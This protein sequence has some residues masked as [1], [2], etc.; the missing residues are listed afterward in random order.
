M[1]AAVAV[2]S[3][4]VIV[5]ASVIA[6]DSVEAEAREVGLGIEAAEGLVVIAVIVVIVTGITAGRQA[7]AVFRALP[8][9]FRQPH[10]QTPPRMPRQDLVV[11]EVASRAPKASRVPVARHT[12]VRGVAAD[13]TAAAAEVGINL[14]THLKT[15]DMV[16]SRPTTTKIA[17]VEHPVEYPV[18][19][20]AERPVDPRGLVVTGTETG[21]TMAGSGATTMTGAAVTVT[22]DAISRAQATPARQ[23]CF[24]GEMKAALTLVLTGSHRSHSPVVHR[25]LLVYIYFTPHFEKRSFYSCYRTPTADWGKYVVYVTACSQSSSRR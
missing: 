8:Q 22:A 9:M 19:R 3:E 10:L 23:K 16:S 15:E 18:D 11:E 13:M 20:P 4:V 2:H 21:A 25:P 14:V 6:A 12:V 17:T 24:S 7:A 5:V 1:I